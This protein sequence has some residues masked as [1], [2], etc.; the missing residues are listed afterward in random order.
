MHT[1]WDRMHRTSTEKS[2]KSCCAPNHIML[3][4]VV[5]SSVSYDTIFVHL[6]QEICFTIICTCKIP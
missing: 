2:S 3:C 6:F 1:A 5:L 4:L